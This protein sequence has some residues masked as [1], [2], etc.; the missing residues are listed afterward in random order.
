VVSLDQNVLP[1]TQLRYV[2]PDPRLV[3]LSFAGRLSDTNPSLVAISQARVGDPVSL[4]WNGNRWRITDKADRILGTM[5]RSFAPPDNA[6]FLRGAI[7]AILGWRKEDND[8]A[9]R[10][11]LRR[12]AWEV[13]LPELVFRS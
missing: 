13:V 9:F 11:M 2:P 3:D 5:S 7:G 12:E 10:N 4:V 8:E 6:A 1:Q